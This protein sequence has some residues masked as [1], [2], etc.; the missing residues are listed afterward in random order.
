MKVGRPPS[1]NVGA[2]IAFLSLVKVDSP[3]SVKVS[4]SILF[5][6]I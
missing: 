2:I 5:L 3:P 1:V 4:V 6:Y